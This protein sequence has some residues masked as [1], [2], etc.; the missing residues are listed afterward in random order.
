MGGGQTA[1]A[2]RTPVAAADHFTGSVRYNPDASV[3]E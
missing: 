2:W 1:V 3:L